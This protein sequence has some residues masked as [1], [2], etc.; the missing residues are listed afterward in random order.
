[1]QTK[2]KSQIEEVDKLIKEQQKA[3]DKKSSHESHQVVRHLTEA[4]A[5]LNLA[6]AYQESHDNKSK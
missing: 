4:R 5:S 3:N 6:R 2:I 1:M